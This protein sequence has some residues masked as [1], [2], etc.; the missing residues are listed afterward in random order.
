MKFP[1]LRLSL[2]VWGLAA[3]IYL[4]GFFQRVTPAS[5]AGDLMRDFS[6]TG[7]GLG[8][9]SAFYFYAYAAMQIPTGV[10]VDRFGPTRLLLFG[11]A[12]AGAGALLFALAPHVGVAAAGRA[13]I[14]AA[15]GIA[16]VSMLKL[17]AHWFA[18]ARFGTMSGLSLTVGTL[19]AVMA[20][21]P[22]RALA[23]AFGWREVIAISGGFALLL[24]LGVLRLMRD[25]PLDRR[26]MTYAPAAAH[27]RVAQAARAAGDHGH[28]VHDLI[29]ILR[30]RNTWLIFWINSGTCGGFLAFA[31][32]W[33]VPFFAQHHGLSVKQA[34]L[35]TSAMLVMFAVGGPLF[36]ALSDRVKR[37][38]WPYVAG[39]APMVAGFGTLAL[40]PDA[41]LAL[42]VPLLL[43]AG[44]G[45][46]AMAVSFGFAKESVP[47]R[48]QGAVTGTVNAG[49]MVGALTLMPLI[50]AVLDAYWQGA[51]AN[52]V[53]LYGLDAFCVGWMLLAGWIAVSFVLLLA[54]RETYARQ[55]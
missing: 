46:G 16:W 47:A 44:F 9:L 24:S 32:L 33:G 54:T 22:L 37:R 21:P 3:A 14:G 51:S 17:V 55:T 53:R 8:N 18:P 49:V 15:H 31:G 28:F 2:M 29:E 43:A 4:F 52:G 48:L 30:Y 36:G 27:A 12:A 20:G 23:D 7:A 50:G 38:K 26:F 42:L 41:P 35:V 6:L 40:V 34:S 45:G 10:L 13:L 5:L 19:G 11:S 39:A 1:P 25:D